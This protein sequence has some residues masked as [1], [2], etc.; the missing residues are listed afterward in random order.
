MWSLAPHDISDHPVSARPGS[1][2]RRRAWACLSSAGVEDVVSLNLLFADGKMA[3]I[4][5]SWLDPRR[6][7][8]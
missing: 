7:S 5:V 2:V 6:T 4:Q 3:Q 8:V 1:S